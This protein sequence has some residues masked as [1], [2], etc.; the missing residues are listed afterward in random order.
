MCK[1][2]LLGSPLV[3]QRSVIS[4]FEAVCLCLMADL[5]KMKL[6]VGFYPDL[7]YMGL[8][9]EGCARTRFFV[10]GQPLIL[11]LCRKD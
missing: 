7:G 5:L 10:P 11:R 8:L 9:G 2:V 6:A 1:D 3:Q 4:Q